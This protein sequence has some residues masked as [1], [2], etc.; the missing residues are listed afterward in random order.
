[1]FNNFFFEN[2]AVYEIIGEVWYSQ[3]G[4]RRQYNT[5]HALCM[6][7]NYGYRLELRLCNTYCFSTATLVTRTRR[8]ITCIRTLR[9][10]SMIN[11]IDVGLHLLNYLKFIGMKR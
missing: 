1:M 11:F 6:L 3:T 4:H 9:V 7:D 5:A 10:L 8:N 2:R